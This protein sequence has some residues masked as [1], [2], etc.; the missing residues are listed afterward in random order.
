[1]KK[2][3][4]AILPDTLVLGIFGTKNYGYFM[5]QGCITYMVLTDRYPGV[6]GII[7]IIENGCKDSNKIIFILDGVKFP[8]DIKKSIT[9]QELLLVCS[10]EDFF[11]KTIFIRGDNVIDF[12]KNLVL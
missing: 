10:N 4:V 2:E 1:M 7:D 11:T 9:C 8:I 5:K 12:D 6:Y 3:E